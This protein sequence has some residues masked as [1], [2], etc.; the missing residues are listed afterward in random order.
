MCESGGYLDYDSLHAY[1]IFGSTVTRY[2]ELR[3]EGVL[4]EGEHVVVG[5][6]TRVGV[7]IH[8]DVS[9]GVSP[10]HLLFDTIEVPRSQQ[11]IQR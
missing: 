1:L 2:L 4:L 7:E 6:N 3:D 10:Q 5:E 11:R 9:I 8:S